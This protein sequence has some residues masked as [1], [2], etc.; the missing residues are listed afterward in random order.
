[1]DDENVE[2]SVVSYTSVLHS[3]FTKFVPITNGPIRARN[4]LG[5]NREINSLKD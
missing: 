4:A 1:M 2:E 3:A 5:F